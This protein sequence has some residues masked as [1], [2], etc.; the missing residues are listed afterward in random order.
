MCVRELGEQD[1]DELP[2]RRTHRAT[3]GSSDIMVALPH[4]ENPPSLTFLQS[5]KTTSGMESLGTRLEG[6]DFYYITAPTP[7]KT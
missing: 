7:I 4:L 3:K 2:P 1:W 6:R 5:Y